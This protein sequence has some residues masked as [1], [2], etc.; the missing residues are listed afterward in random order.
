MFV[1]RS[2]LFRAILSVAVFAV[3]ASTPLF[4]QTTSGN[5][6]GTVTAGSDALPG[7]TI[8]A[9]HVPTGTRY[10]TVS[11]G[12][13]RYVIP[14]A[15]VGGPYKVTATLEGFKTY[16]VTVPT[17]SLGT[18]VE[19]PVSMAM[20]AVTEAITVTARADNIINPNK[21]GSSSSVS[22]EQIQTLPTVNRQLQDFARTNPYVVTSLT[23]DG[24]FMTIAGRNNRYNNIQIDGAVNNDLFGLAASGT[25]GGQAGTQPVSLDAIQELQVL[26][27]PYDVRQS[28]FTG[29]GLNA[30]TRS[31]TNAFE[32]SVFGTKRNPDFVGEGPSGTKVTEFEQTQYGGRIGGPIMRDK[33]F[34]F[35]SGESNKRKDPQGTSATPGATGT[36]Y[37]I[38]SSGNVIPNLPSAAA[39]A[40]FFQSK[41]GLDVGGLG[42]LVFDT[43]SKLFFGRLD[44]NLGNSNNLTLR[45]NYV[46]ATQDNAPSSFVRST[47]RFYYP[48]NIYGFPSKTNSTVAQLNSVFGANLFN[49]GR[50]GYQTIR[51]SR[52]TPVTFPTVEIGPGGERAGTIQAGTERFSGA[53]ALDQTILEITDDITFTRGNHTIVVGTH[54]ELFEFSNLFISDFYGYYHFANFAAL[55]AGTPDIYRI[56][57]ATGADPKRPTE[58]KAAQYSLYVSDQFQVNPALRLTFGLRADKPKFNTTPSFNPAVQTAIGFSTSAIP[59][60]KISWEPRI[61]FNWD[62]GAAGKQQL[63]GGVGVFQGRTPFVWISN[64]YGN[65]GVETVALGCTTAACLPVFNP[66]VNTQPRNLGTGAVQDISLSDP[67]F[68]F[69][70]VLRTTIGYDRELFWGIRGS[71]EVLWSQTQK[72]VY[73]RNVNKQRTATSPLDGRPRYASIASTI[74]NAYFLTNTSE[75]NEQTETIQLN[76]TFR[77]LTLTASY[78]HQNAESAGEGN[79]S[80]ASSNWQFGFITRGDINVPEIS[81]S[82]FQIKHRYNI[83]STYNLATGPLTHS[84]GLYYVAQAGQPYSLIMGGDVNGDGSANNDLLFIPADLILCPS[85]SNGAPNA[86]AACRTS[87]GVTQPA[88]DKALFSS[89]LDSVGLQAGS[90]KA[91]KR[92]SLSQPWTRRL[93]FHYEIGLPPIMGARLLVQADVLNLLN[94]F[95]SDTGVQRFVLNNTYMPVTYSGQ[96]PTSGLPVYR[97]TA[98]GRLTPGSQYSTA[99]IGSRWQGRLGLRVNF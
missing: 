76:K 12:N 40:D 49:E 56:G 42:D 30:V 4:A 54:N 28:G 36:V 52:D 37:G 65:T 78:A 39:V 27:S 57:F 19:V 87:A 84:F 11:G 70:R 75:G 43:Q 83:A 82:S 48:T 58:F 15:R 61:G 17:V 55:Q 79:S 21:T 7:V 77:N 92:N 6:A 71:A 2:S 93:D 46:D 81:T 33:L 95:D 80:T 47:T 98:G 25:P 88:L 26:I 41:Y 22:E 35:V 72:D 53:N 89:F 69:P 18:T 38:D 50:V 66:D 60:E 20:S 9:V 62:I 86:T 5:I 32:G 94:I 13:G 85:T 1:R 8:E 3:L 45:H 51:E 74:G 99:N 16:A 97:E 67:N 90:G 59:S 34:F 73:Y 63:R 91:P 10:D 29:G 44:T 96:D 31:G 68:R 14:N 23:S 64:N 24:T